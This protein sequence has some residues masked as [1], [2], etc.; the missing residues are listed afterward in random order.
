MLALGGVVDGEGC[1]PLGTWHGYACIE[2]IIT[3]VRFGT[4]DVSVD[5]I[6]S[7]VC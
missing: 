4:R 5:I 7:H 2:S 3:Q 1:I 6:C